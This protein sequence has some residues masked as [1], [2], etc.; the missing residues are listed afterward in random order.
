MQCKPPKLYTFHTTLPFF[1]TPSPYEDF[2]LINIQMSPSR[3]GLWSHI[4]I[5]LANIAYNRDDDG[6]HIDS[7]TP[8][9]GVA[10]PQPDPSDKRTPGILHSFYGQVGLG[11]SSSQ[12]PS[13][14]IS[15]IS[16][17]SSSPNPSEP[18][19]H[20]NSPRQQFEAGDALSKVTPSSVDEPEGETDSGAEKTNPLLQ[21]H[22]LLGSSQISR[23][24]H[25]YPTPPVSHPSSLHKLNL[26]D[27]TFED[28][29]NNVQNTTA[30]VDRDCTSESIPFHAK[31]AS[32]MT[33]LS[34]IVTPSNV[35]AAHFSNPSDIPSEHKLSTPPLSRLHSYFHKSPSYDRLKKLTCDG[36]K[37]TPSTPTRALS[38]QTS[39]SDQ[40][41]MSTDFGNAAQN[42]NGQNGKSSTSDRP[43][44][45]PRV[46]SSMGGAVVPPKGKLTVKINEARGLRKSLDPYVVAVFQRNELVSKGP[47]SDEDD[48]DGDNSHS[49]GGIPIGGIPISRTG[50]DSGRP[51]AIPMKSRQ[52][53]NTSL[54]EYRDFKNKGRKMFA[55]P[56]WDAEAVL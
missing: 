29:G 42:G 43:A 20:S 33:P 25:F 17:L 30:P 52:S 31:R 22:E 24:Q 14:H 38:N 40:S 16:L 36:S 51:M 11:S 56:K 5:T 41:V 32:S 15:H 7:D 55:H 53:S 47:Q 48:E 26:S 21:S 6:D 45:P 44:A 27:A 19:S 18:E 39:K 3:H 10:T 8:R 13:K 46:E 50:S 23:Q 35:H 49:P 34:N 28:V 1:T 4:N 54:S 2:T 12:N 37:S 9:S